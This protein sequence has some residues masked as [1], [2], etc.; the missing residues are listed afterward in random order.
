MIKITS[1]GKI[2]ERFYKEAMEEYK[3]R[4]EKF[5]KIEIK[6]TE[7]IRIEENA[8][9]IFLDEKGE[10]MD[11]ISFAKFLKEAMLKHKNIHFYIGSY[12][13]FDDNEKNKADFILSLSKMTFPYQ[14]CRIILLEQIYRAMTIIRNM[15][16]HK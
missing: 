8:F 16:Y 7:D 11:S 2:K 3:K 6:E 4:I 10:E 14:L 1:L 12:E 15:P 5:V 13:G 9:K